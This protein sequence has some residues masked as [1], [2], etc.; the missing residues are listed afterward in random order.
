MGEIVARTENSVPNISLFH[1]SSEEQLPLA[2]SRM[3]A[4]DSACLVVV[5]EPGITLDRGRELVRPYQSMLPVGTVEEV[6]L[7][8]LSRRIDELRRS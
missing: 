5:C 3:I 2:M 7:E 6:A 8:D 1:C 4:S